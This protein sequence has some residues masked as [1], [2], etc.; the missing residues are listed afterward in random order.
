MS[1][2]EMQQPEVSPD[3]H[4]IY[5]G[6]YQEETT[7]SNQDMT[8]QKLFV[9]QVQGES[10]STPTTTHRLI[11]AMSSLFIWMTIL[12]GFILLKMYSTDWTVVP[13]A[14]IIMLLLTGLLIAINIIYSRRR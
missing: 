6:G 13:F 11:L 4:P 10:H 7:Y 2:Q 3:P 9:A 12:F 8:G 5:A 14:L 1:Q